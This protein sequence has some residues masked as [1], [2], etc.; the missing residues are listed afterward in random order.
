[1]CI[2]SDNAKDTNTEY[3]VSEEDKD[4]QDSSCWESNVLTTLNSNLDNP[5]KALSIR[6]DVVH[7][8]MIR[9]VKRFYLKLFKQQNIK[10]F[11]KRIVNSRVQDILK[12]LSKMCETFSGTENPDD[13]AEF[14]LKFLALKPKN[15][16]QYS[17][18][19]EKN[20]ELAI[21]C[22]YNYSYGKFAKL[23]TVKEFSLLFVN[24]YE[25]H[26]EEVF[27]AEKKTLKLHS[28]IYARAFQSLYS[29]CKRN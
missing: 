28:E 8:T 15:Y 29:K 22:M 9:A 5:Q 13:L 27:E 20:A 4:H 11:R 17:F 2:A 19:S 10:L 14:L 26:S 18:A 25:N 1:M 23:C 6:E 7:K 24:L 12:A 21:T 16:M 3:S